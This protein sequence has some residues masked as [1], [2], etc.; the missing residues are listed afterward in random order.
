MFEEGRRNKEPIKGLSG[1]QQDSDKELEGD[2][3]S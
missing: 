1:H 2:G 3:E